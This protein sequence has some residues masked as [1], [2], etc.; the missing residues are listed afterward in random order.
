VE[1]WR[2]NWH[3]SRFQEVS[4]TP[5][6]FKKNH[7]YRTFWISYRCAVPVC[8]SVPGNITTHTRIPVSCRVIHNLQSQV[9]W[10]L[11][12]HILL[13]LNKYWITTF[14]EK[15][16]NAFVRF[17]NNITAYP[18]A[19]SLLT[20]FFSVPFHAFLFSYGVYIFLSPPSSV[21]ISDEQILGTRKQGC[22]LETRLARRQ[23]YRPFCHYQVCRRGVV[24]QN[25]FV[26]TD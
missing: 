25:S 22:K 7:L 15:H 13:S 26:F 4:F 10:H 18:F 23:S 2:I 19:V 9:F 24:T 21:L 12:Y 1:G 20:Q 6:V 5:G 17:A 14:H 16:E 11:L 3:I 8:L